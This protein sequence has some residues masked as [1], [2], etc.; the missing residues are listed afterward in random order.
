MLKALTDVATWTRMKFKPAKSRS[1]VIKKGKTT[2]RFKLHIQN[3]EIASIVKG[4]IKWLGKWFDA[5]LQD[6]D[7][8]KMLKNQVEEGLKKINHYGLSGKFKD[9]LYQNSTTTTDM[10][11]DAVRST[12]STVEALERITSR[13]PR[14]WLWVPPSFTSIGLYGKSNNL[15]LPLS[16]LVEEFKTANTRLVLTLR[17]SPWRRD[18][19]SNGQEVVSNRDRESGREL[20]QA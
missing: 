19:N 3:E 9:W 5:I 16:S 8:V 10:V 12:S 4:P 11:I 18:C 20:P 6:R 7:N 15:Q 14:K 13:H 1:F 17:D 2:V